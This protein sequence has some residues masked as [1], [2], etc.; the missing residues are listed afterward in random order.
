VK[1][2]EAATANGDGDQRQQTAAEN[3]VSDGDQQ[4]GTANGDSEQR[5]PKTENLNNRP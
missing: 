2:P 3:S 1:T 5:R 4:S